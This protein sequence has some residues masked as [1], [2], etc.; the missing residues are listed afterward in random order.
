VDKYQ[1]SRLG[2]S[3]VDSVY[4][5]STTGNSTSVNEQGEVDLRQPWSNLD[6]YP[7]A[8]ASIIFTVMFQF[9]KPH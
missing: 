4:Y 6:P 7:M 1:R 8:G 3:Q 5:S 9:P 2:F